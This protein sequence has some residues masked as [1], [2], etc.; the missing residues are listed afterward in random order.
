MRIGKLLKGDEGVTVKTIAILVACAGFCL[1]AGI[2]FTRNSDTTFAATKTLHLPESAPSA[3]TVL[4]DLRE[5][6]TVLPPSRWAD[7]LPEGDGK[8]FV[9]KRCVIC[10]D[11]H[12]VVAFPRPANQ[13]KD[14][15]DTMLRRGAPV[16]PDEKDKIVDYLTTNLGPAALHPIEKSCTASP[17]P[18]STAKYFLY[19]SNQWGASVDV[20]DPVVNKV[21][22]T[23]KCISSP[24]GV[25]FSP[26]GT[27]AYIS[28]RVQHNLAV[29]NTKSGEIIKKIPVTARP[30]WPMI[31]KDGKKIFVAIWPLR[32]DEDSRGFIDVIDTASL[33]K[34][35]SIPTKGGIHDMYLT[36]N[37]KNLVVG[38]PEGHF[39]SVYD[40]QTEKLEWE[41]KFDS[42]VLT[43]SVEGDPKGDTKRI[44]VDNIFP[45]FKVVDFATHK[46][47]EKVDFPDAD[48]A[49]SLGWW[50][51]SEISSDEKMLWL[52]GMGYGSTQNNVV[53]AYS[54]PS[55]KPAGEVHMSNLDGSEKPVA[56]Y[57]SDGRWLS[58]SPDGSRVYVVE[59]PL[60]V[61][62]V[63][64]AMTMK[65]ITRIPVGEGPLQISTLAVQ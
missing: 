23:I 10:H 17:R 18:P 3:A 42:P 7:Q 64:D 28:D 56:P 54:L 46:Q 12:R 25:V 20:I 16:P 44:F 19:V 21:V 32:P 63:I 31:T 24:E 55:L 59:R 22:Q 65:E 45:G 26:D 8:Q 39:L 50:H 30:N 62:S 14:A 53:Y 43:M 29:V 15:V 34:V 49:G 13:W 48:P 27:L 1:Y 60:E 61:V 35:R 52:A 38:S 6:H 37:G 2:G 4:P 47:A 41:V 36:P 11:L 57:K 9:T 5:F 33:T 51:G 58:L 40:V